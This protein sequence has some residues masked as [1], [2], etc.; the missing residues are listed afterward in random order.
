VL[1]GRYKGLLVEADEYLLALSR[2]IHLNPVRIK[3]QESLSEEEKK[4]FLRKY[5]WS[6][7]SGYVQVRSRADYV[8]YDMVLGYRGADTEKTRK[9][10]EEFVYD[11]LREDLSGMYEDVKGQVVLGGEGFLKWVQEHFLE[12]KQIKEKDIANINELKREIPLKEIAVLVA[13][14]YGVSD[15]ELLKKRSKQRQARQVLIELSY[16]SN[17]GKKSL[18]ELGAELGGIGGDGVLQTHKRVQAKLLTNEVLVQKI[19]AIKKRLFSQ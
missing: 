16:Q 10:Y 15:E 3:K 4:D 8:H 9:R 18:R 7:F 17:A 2:Y 14:E 5:R 13:E 12:G 19:D 1:Q 11:G 6:S